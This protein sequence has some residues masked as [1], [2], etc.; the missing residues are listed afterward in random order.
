MEKD[1][2]LINLEKGLSHSKGWVEGSI[3]PAGHG[4]P[5]PTKFSIGH[6]PDVSVILNAHFKGFVWFITNIMSLKHM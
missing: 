1:P 6:S 5:V 2:A 3:T 4:N